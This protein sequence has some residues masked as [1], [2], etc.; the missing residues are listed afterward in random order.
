MAMELILIRHGESEG[1]IGLTD[2]PDCGL[3]PR[4]RE[5]ARQL[6]RRLARHDLVGFSG[7]VSPYRRTRDTAAEIA[8]ASGLAFVVDDA[9][10]EWGPPATIDGRHFPAETREQLADRLGDFLNRQAGRKLIVVSHAAPI[11]VLTPLVW[12]E[13]PNLQGA[14]WE[15]VSNCCPR[16]LKAV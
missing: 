2:D 3:T 4:G 16:W 8:A 15:G 6:G 1:N 11:A 7:I 14:F 5:Q 12:G 13:R 10:R 9:I